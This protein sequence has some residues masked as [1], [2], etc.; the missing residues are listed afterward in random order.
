MIRSSLV[1]L[2]VVAMTSLFG[3]ADTAQAQNSFFNYVIAR[4]QAIENGSFAPGRG[5]S[6]TTL[7]NAR[8]IRTMTPMVPTPSTPSIGGGP[9]GLFRRT[10]TLSPAFRRSNL[11]AIRYGTVTPSGSPVRPVSPISWR[12]IFGRR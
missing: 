12:A 7:F 11:A 8:G 10:L 4:R 1:L 3:P 5:Q 6:F 2:A 9:S